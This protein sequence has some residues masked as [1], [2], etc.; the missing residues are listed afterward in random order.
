MLSVGDSGTGRGFCKRVFP[1]GNT[2]YGFYSFYE[3]IAGPEATRILILK[4]GPGVGKS[5]FMRR[6]AE[7]L[8]ERGYDVELHQCS[9]DHDSLD[10]VVI[11]GAGVALID[12]TAP[13]VLDPRHPGCVDEILHLGD[14]W[15]ERGMRSHRERIVEC[16]RRIGHLFAH[17]YR[18]LRAAKE[19]YDDRAAIHSR[20]LECGRANRLAVEL[21]ERICGSAP[22]A[23]VPGKA[24]HLFASA[25]SPRGLVH[26]LE[27]ILGRLPRVVVLQGPPGSGKSTLLQKV[28]AHVQERGFDVECYHCSLDPARLEHLVVPALGVGVVTSAEPHLY[29]PPQPEA[30]VDL[31]TCLR[32]G[33]LASWARVAQEDRRIYRELLERAISFIARAKEV[34][35]EMEGYYTPHMDFAAIDELRE[36]TLQRILSYCREAA[37]APSSA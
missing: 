18:F 6:I 11:P 26:H 1:G 28:A 22:V 25:I 3:Y 14:F 20:A 16:N 13:H 17:A 23:E 24:R 27:T 21:G 30:V 34:H 4:G 33:E 32:A 10:G 9:S 36:R 2:A 35:D 15:D 12:G 29:W 19:I 8:L 31:G 7:A 5:T 37:G